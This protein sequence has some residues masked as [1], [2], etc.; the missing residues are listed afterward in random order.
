MALHPAAGGSGGPGGAGLAAASHRDLPSLAEAVL[1]RGAAQAWAAAEDIASLRDAFG[2]AYELGMRPGERPRE[3]D[4][5][6]ISLRREVGGWTHW[7]SHLSAALL[8]RLAERDGELLL[9]PPV[10]QGPGGGP[11]RSPRS[12]WRAGASPN[13][14]SAAAGVDHVR[15]W[16]ALAA[17]AALPEPSAPPPPSLP[18]VPP[19]PSLPSAPPPPALSGDALAALGASARALVRLTPGELG[20]RQCVAVLSAGAALVAAGRLP[21]GWG[22]PKLWRHLARCAA[23]GAGPASGAELSGAFLALGRLA[24]EF[25]PRVSERALRCLEAEVARRLAGEGEGAAQ[26]EEAVTGNVAV[27]LGKGDGQSPPRAPAQPA[28]LGNGGRDGGSGRHLAPQQLAGILWGCAKLHRWRADSDGSG[29]YRYRYLYCLYRRATGGAFLQRLAA[30]LG[31]S[32]R[33]LGAAQIVGCLHALATLGCCGPEYGPSVGA[34]AEAALAILATRP[35]DVSDRDLSALLC[36]LAALLNAS[37]SG[38]GAGAGDSSVARLEAAAPLGA[39]QK[40]LQ[41]AAAGSGTGGVASSEAAPLGAPRP[42]PGGVGIGPEGPPATRHAPPH[43]YCGGGGGGGG[44]SGGGGGEAP[45]RALVDATVAEWLRR[46]LAS[47]HRSDLINA[48]SALASLV[49]GTA[50]PTAHVGQDRP[51]PEQYERWF[52]SAARAAT[53]PGFVDG[54]TAADLVALL[55]AMAAV[56]QRPP[57]AMLSLWAQV[58]DLALHWA[59]FQHRAAGLWSLAVLY[60]D[61]RRLEAADRAAVNAV[62]LSPAPLSGAGLLRAMQDALVEVHLRDSPGSYPGPPS[63]A[64]TSTSTSTPTSAL[65]SAAASSPMTDPREQEV[66]RALEGLARPQQPP[67]A[68]RPGRQGGKAASAART[69]VVSV[70]R[71]PWLPDLGRSVGAVVGLAGGRQV[72]VEVD[73]PGRFLAG[74]EQQQ[75]RQRRRTRDGVTQ[76]RDRQLGRALGPD[77]VLSVPYWEW[78]ELGG[79]RV[80]QEAYLVRRLRGAR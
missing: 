33:A 66:L 43:G 42:P 64:S 50:D 71:R 1:R 24:E 28:A 27:E 40:T 3:D 2:L 37:G 7:G 54:A 70:R 73:G 46:D 59:E 57:A 20:P 55:H 4:P 49:R 25:D 44:G 38:A 29:S 13:W 10:Q 39:P 16:E 36:D 15:L 11:E 18:S 60:G 23:E 6:L 72:A 65:A 26:G 80:A 14:R 45:A 9:T 41:T 77:N 19:P 31:S 12:R 34:L 17:A 69:V 56:R 51:Y 62:Q 58:R 79:N 76:L 21:E 68:A 35:Q 63:T 48:A 47:P 52:R 74:G 78:D 30:A 53:Q 67:T 8:A 32:A 22:K 61:L 75:Q 5:E